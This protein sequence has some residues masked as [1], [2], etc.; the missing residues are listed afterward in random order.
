MLFLLLQQAKKNF[1]SLKHKVAWIIF[2]T[3][4]TGGDK[5]TTATAE[6]TRNEQRKLKELILEKR[7][8]VRQMCYSE[9]H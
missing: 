4:F 3:E 8:K 2:L 9:A 1:S 7:A 5:H 6:E